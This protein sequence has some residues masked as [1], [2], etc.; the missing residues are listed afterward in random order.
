MEITLKDLKE[1]KACSEQVEIFRAL[2]GK[3]GQVTLAKCRLAAKA[4]LNFNWASSYFLDPAQRVEYARVT[5]PALAKYERV[6][7]LAYERITALALAEYWRAA[8]LAFHQAT[9]IK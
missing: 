9:L 7:A 3:G 5:A 1:K 4:G 2:F 6:T 8:A